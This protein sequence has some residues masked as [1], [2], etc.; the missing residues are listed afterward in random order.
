MIKATPSSRSTWIRSSITLAIAGALGMGLAACS[1]ST[2][3][4]KPATSSSMPPSTTSPLVKNATVDTAVSSQY[5][6]ILVNASGMTLYMLTGDTSTASICTT[7]C[8]AVWP[9]LTTT[10]TPTAGTGVGSGM[11]GTITR[12]DGTRQV[13]FNGHPLYTFVPDGSA[14]KVTG[15]GINHF[16]GIW[17]VLGATGQPVTSAQSGG[18]VTTVPSGSGTTTSSAGASNGST[19]TAAG[20]Y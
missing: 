2:S 13:T 8:A 1:S 12:S 5:G 10:G 9:P 19:T 3:P 11:L 18:A 17:Y 20:S 6:T 14:G 4:P 15:E 16:G 7:A